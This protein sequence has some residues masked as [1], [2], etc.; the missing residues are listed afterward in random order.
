MDLTACDAFL[1][2]QLTDYLFL[3]EELSKSTEALKDLPKPEIRKSG[4][5]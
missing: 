3:E 5:W 4:K 2:G 1:S